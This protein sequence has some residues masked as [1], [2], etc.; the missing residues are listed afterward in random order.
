MHIPVFDT[1]RV[2]QPTHP[3]LSVGLLWT[4]D[5]PGAETSI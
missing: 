3:H 1:S 5:K 4:S 2:I